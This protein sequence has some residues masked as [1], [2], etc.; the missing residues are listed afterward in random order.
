MIVKYNKKKHEIDLILLVKENFNYDFYIT[1]NNNRI[2]IKD[3]ISIKKL[4]RNVTIAYISENKS[5]IDGVMLIWQ[6]VGANVKR[7]Y[8]K[9]NVLNKKVAENLLNTLVQDYKGKLYIKIKKD[10]LYLQLFKDNDF[11]FCHDRG[12]E[13]LLVKEKN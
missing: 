10:S 5:E 13:L 1:E 12:S 2:I 7:N 6:A 9:F 4:F 3:N 8:V 11:R